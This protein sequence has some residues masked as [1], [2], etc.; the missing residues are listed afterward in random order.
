MQVENY[1][2]QVGAVRDKLL[3][4]QVK[5]EDYCVVGITSEQFKK[6]FPESFLRGKS[7]EVFELNGKEFAMA[8]TEKKTG[9]GHKEF[10]ISTNKNISNYKEDELKQILNNGSYIKNVSGN[11]KKFDRL[12][13][14]M[15]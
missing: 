11:I 14:K 6:L 13:A 2:Q 15:K 12:W 10:E 1:I 4:K 3:N 9:I 8:R 7:F 5:D